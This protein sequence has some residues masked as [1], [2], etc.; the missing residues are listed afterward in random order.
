[1]NKATASFLNET[2]A[3]VLTKPLDTNELRE[4]ID[5]IITAK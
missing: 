4:T 5:K 3:P 1:M 2:Q